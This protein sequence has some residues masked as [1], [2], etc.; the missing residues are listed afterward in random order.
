MRLSIIIP[1]FNVEQYIKKC[2]HS[3]LRQNVLASDYEIIVVND[4]STDDSL[5]FAKEVA[6]MANNIIIISQEN[7]GLGAARNKGL[8]LA[9][10]EFV[11][12]V[13]ADDW[14]EENC[15]NEIFTLCTLS[16]VVHVGHNIVENGKIVSKDAIIVEDGL[17]LSAKSIYHC[18]PFYIIRR[19]LLIIN[20]L[21]FIPGIFHEDT[22]FVPRM[23]YYAR[24][25][26]SMNSCVYNYLHRP[27][28]IMSTV[29]PKRSF[30]LIKVMSSLYDFQ[31]NVV[32][33]KDRY[34]YDD[35]ISLCLNNALY[36]ISKCPKSSQSEWGQQIHAHKHL[37]SALC[38]STSLK[39][40]VQGI[41]FLS[42]PLFNKIVFYR[43]MQ[44]F[45]IINRR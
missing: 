37:F 2:I 34:I 40:K 12:F 36:V 33:K 17:F 18:A 27:A 29:N 1:M 45:N 9:Q 6:A 32:E 23:L 22:E 41:M 25:V 26:T 14:I 38:R 4:G 39:Y 31:Q 5:L 30:D 10:G 3:C 42:F 13:D 44:L 15:L 21:Y 7:Q 24:T 8:S 19:S 16:D 11:W 28:S 35:L 20:N 43:F